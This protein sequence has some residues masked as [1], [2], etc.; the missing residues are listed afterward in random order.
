M[1]MW[2]E[3]AELLEHE[4][5]SSSYGK[6]EVL[7]ANGSTDSPVRSSNCTSGLAP[8]PAPVS[9]PSDSIAGDVVKKYT[10]DQI[11]HF[12]NGLSSRRLGRGGFGTVYLGKLENGKEVAVKILDPSSQQGMPKFLNEVLMWMFTSFERIMFMS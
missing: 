11:R 9:K 4:L 2:K 6:A 5:A 10:W 3:D 12:R 1:K 8:E 7:S